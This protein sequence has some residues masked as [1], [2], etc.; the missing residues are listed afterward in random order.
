MN[1]CCHAALS[2]DK[3]W[4]WISEFLRKCHDNPDIDGLFRAVVKEFE[5]TIAD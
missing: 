2:H 5:V 1:Q 3:T 4:A